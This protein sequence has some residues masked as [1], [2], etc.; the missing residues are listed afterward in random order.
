MLAPT[1]VQVKPGELFIGGKFVPAESGESF[2]TINPAT[3]LTLTTVAEAGPS[4]VYAA[5]AAARQAFDSGPWSKM[6]VSARGRVLWKIADFIMKRREEIAELETLDSGKPI[7]D[8]TRIDVP[9]AA[10]CFQYYAGWA[11]KIHGSTIPVAGPYFNYTLREPIGVVGAIV[12]WNFPFLM[13]AWKIAPALCTG[14][15]VV[16]K[17]A[18]QTSLTALLLAEI[19]AEA[20]LPEGVLNVLPGPGGAVGMAIVTHPGVDKIAFTGST[21]VGQE[22]LRASVD[23]LKHVGLELGGKSP[24][25]VF[26]DADMDNAVRGASIGIFYNEGQ[27]CTAASRLF[28]EDS[29]HDEFMEKLVSRTR[30]MVA[31]DPLDP[32]TRYGP[33]VSE[34]QMNTVLR[35]IG[36]GKEEGAT[37][38]TGGGRATVEGC[39]GYYVEPT[40]FDDVSNNMTIARDEIFGPVLSVIRFKD[41]E[42]G[43]RLANDSMYGLASA[44]WT[45]DIKRAHRVAKRIKAGTVWINTVNALDNST[46]FGGYKMSGLGRELG[47][48]ALDHY[49]QTKSVWVDLS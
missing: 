43:V 17:P 4:D 20:G 13:A 22:I 24:S 16:L 1:R 32:R 49:T 42:E 41:E 19:C 34:E 23:T 44:I 45:K 46:P 15:T 7:T 27:I 48:A 25:L 39:D 10:D 11:T 35:Y 36:I 33:Q 2:E 28:V 21:V 40:I 47:E 37:C 31:G 3:G 12:P 8:N 14:N 9:M 38:V 5:V 30:K 26:A 6:S 29:I 18:R